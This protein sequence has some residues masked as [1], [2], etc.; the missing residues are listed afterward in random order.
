MCIINVIILYSC[1]VYQDMTG[2][3]ASYLATLKSEISEM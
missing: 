3:V 2:S 1:E